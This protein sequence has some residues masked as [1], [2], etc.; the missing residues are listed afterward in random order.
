[1][2]F[3]EVYQKAVATTKVVRHRQPN[4]FLASDT[5]LPFVLLHESEI[6][7]GDTVVRQGKVTVSAAHLVVPGREHEFE[8]FGEDFPERYLCILGR[9]ASM[10]LG[11]YA[12]ECSVDV[13]EGSIQ[14]ALDHFQR[15]MEDDE[16][17]GLCVCEGDVW[18]LAVCLYVGKMVLRSAPSDFNDFM[19]RIG[20]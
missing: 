15:K 10:P 11:K 6:N 12:L 20:E 2:E 1:M 16:E 7:V 9:M 14:K 4:L 18:Q 8:G 17:G 3:Q 13:F 5:V 19:T